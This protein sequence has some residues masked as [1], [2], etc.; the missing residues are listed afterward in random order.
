MARHLKNDDIGGYVRFSVSAAEKAMIEQAA[1]AQKRSV[2]DY[3]RISCLRDAQEVLQKQ[4]MYE[5]RELTVALVNM[6]RN[7]GATPEFLKGFMDFVMQLDKEKENEK[8]SKKK[9]A[10]SV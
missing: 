10:K 5:T 6:V 3:A 2:A 7:I 1:L 8:K 9:T 4:A